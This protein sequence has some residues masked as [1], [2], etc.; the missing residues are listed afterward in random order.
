MF[1]IV[2]TEVDESPLP[3]ESVRAYVVRL[4]VAKARAAAGH[5]RPESLIVAADTAVVYDEKI[6]GKPADAV[7]AA[8]MLRRLRG[9]THQVHT[10][11]AVLRPSDDTLLTDCCTTN[12]PMRHYSET[13][14]IAY[15]ATGDPFDKAGGY[16]IQNLVFSPAARKQGCYANVMGL[17]LCHLTRTLAAMGFPPRADV[18]SA[19]QTVL[20]YHCPVYRRVLQG[21]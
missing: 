4:A 8:S 6:L 15:I 11:L 14:I 20:Q 18:S 5:V 19:C 17:P 2:P 1:H 16:G 10:G 12:V 13:E 9:R 21:K 3:N 7:E